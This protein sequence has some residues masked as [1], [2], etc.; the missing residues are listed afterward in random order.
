MTGVPTTTTGLPSCL[1]D[2]GGFGF[3]NP[4][5]RLEGWIGMDWGAGFPISQNS[6][7]EH[8]EKR[9]GT[10][11]KLFDWLFLQ[12]YWRHMTKNHATPPVHRCSRYDTSFRSHGM[13]QARFGYD[14]DKTIP[15]THSLHL[16][17][18]EAVPRCADVHPSS[19][20][21]VGRSTVPHLHTSSRVSVIAP[22][23][24]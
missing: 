15:L 21:G 7:I 1:K 23:Y 12:R 17:S 20:C 9:C 19:S 11:E 4:R 3:Q 16:A 14:Q 18:F 5:T 8:Q 22:E 13:S 2:R 10:Y 6:A 24:Q